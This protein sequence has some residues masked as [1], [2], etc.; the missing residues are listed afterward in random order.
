MLIIPESTNPLDECGRPVGGT[1]RGTGLAIDWQNGPLGRDESR[2]QPNGAFT[3]NVIYAVLQRLEHFQTTQFKCRENALAI[4]K[5]EESLH[6]LHSRT[7]RREAAKTEGTH[8]PD[9]EKATP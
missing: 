3:E 7:M 6:W 1:V 2:I 8:I 9:T 5:L 4:T